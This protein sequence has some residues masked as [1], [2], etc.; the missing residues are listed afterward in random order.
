MLLRMHELTRI[1]IERRSERGAIDFDL[2]E[3]ELRFN[4]EGKIGGIVRSERNIAHRLIEEFMLLANETVATHLEKLEVPSVYRIHEE[5]D[6][7]KI[8]EF[9][10]VASSFGHKFSMHGPVP[11]RGFQHLLRQVE[12]S[13]EERMLSYLMLRSMERLSN[14]PSIKCAL[15][16]W[17]DGPGIRALQKE[18]YPSGEGSH[19]TAS[20]VALTWYKYPETM[21]RTQLE[22]RIA[23]NGTF[24]DAEDYRRTFPDGRIGSDPSQATP[25]HGK[26][27]YDTAVEEV[28]RDYEKWVA[29]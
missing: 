3:A 16:N 12:G 22:P 20:E 6:P 4:D 14:Q 24:A 18:L 25:E 5:P 23:P 9:Q 1:L 26:R 17:W 10:D 28:A 8:E 2:P 15:R 19:A 13:P 11:Q 7:A 21:N 27:F 29:R